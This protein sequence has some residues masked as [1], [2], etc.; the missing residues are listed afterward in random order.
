[1]ALSRI[2]AQQAAEI[3]QHDWSDAPYRADKAGHD[4]S[5]DGRQASSEQLT[6]DQVVRLKM[7]VAWVTAQVLAY[8]DPNFSEHEYFQAC[9]LES[10]N[11]NGRPSATVTYG[12]RHGPAADGSGTRRFQIPGTYRFDEPETPPTA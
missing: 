1:M 3:K 2:A 12:L 8:N 9:G 5:M 4:R 7:N 10:R 11:S 6:P